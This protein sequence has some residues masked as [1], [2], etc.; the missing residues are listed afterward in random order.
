M[1]PRDFADADRGFIAALEPCVVKAADGRVVWDNDVYS[2][3]SGDAPTTVH[4]SLWRQS[5]LA[6]KQGLY[7]VVEGIYQVRGPGSV[8]CEL[9]R[10]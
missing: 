9:H 6:A 4:P 1:T 3:L 5:A 10:G 2:F 7:E 8:E